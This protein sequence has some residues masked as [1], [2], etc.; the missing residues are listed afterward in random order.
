MKPNKIDE[1]TKNLYPEVDTSNT[2]RKRKIIERVLIVLALIGSAAVFGL[3]S[4][5]FGRYVEQTYPKSDVYGEWQ[6]QKVAEYAKEYI[7]LSD[8]GV[9]KDGNLIST[10]FDYDGRYLEYTTGEGVF[11]YRFTDDARTQMVQVSDNHYNPVFILV[12]KHKKQL[13]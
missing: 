11:R 7:L 4:D 6:E 10:S 13:R 3:Y 8:D 1:I 5:L 12:G 9:I 2:K